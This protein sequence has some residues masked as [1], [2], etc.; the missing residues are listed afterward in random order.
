MSAQWL[1]SYL[2]L[3]AAL[4]IAAGSDLRSRRIPN[5]LTLPLA[6]SGLLLAGL[7]SSRAEGAISFGG[8]AA[9]LGVGLAVPFVFFAIGALGAG[10]VKLLAA[11]GAWVGVKPILIIML[12]AAIIGGVLAVVQALMQ[13]RLALVLGNTTLL[14]MNLVNV[15]RFGTARVVAMSA[16]SPS[17]N[18]AL[19]YGVAIALATVCFIVGRTAGWVIA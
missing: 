5:S 18:N 1:L 6:L 14:A 16:E 9:G 4:V 15:R 8:A 10:D 7:P 11:V 17:L 2:P 3:L 12:A 19:P 13:R